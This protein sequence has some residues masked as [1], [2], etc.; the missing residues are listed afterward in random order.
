MPQRVTKLARFLHGAT[1]ATMIILPFLIAYGLLGPWMASGTWSGLAMLPTDVAPLQFVLS[2]LIGLLVPLI[3]LLTLN[4]MRKLFGAYAGKEILTAHC[5]R[6][7]QRIGQGF[8]ALAFVSFA[9]GPVQSVLLTMGNLPG[10]HS[11]VVA[12]TNDMVFFALSGGLIIV[13]GW[14]MREASEAAAE[15]KLIV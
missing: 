12:L 2:F 7:I 15:N 1:L 3:F 9:Q 14:A 6:L 4:E 5:A 11:L 8:L 10:E 13:I